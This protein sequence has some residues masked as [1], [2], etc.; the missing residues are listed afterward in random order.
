METQIILQ[1][2]SLILLI[3][4]IYLGAKY[5]KARRKFKEFRELID[6]IDELWE[7]YETN[8][9]E[10]EKQWEKVIKEAKDLLEDP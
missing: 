4:S 9:Q 10:I 5:K 3:A 7:T 1:I 6:A 8:P 2:I